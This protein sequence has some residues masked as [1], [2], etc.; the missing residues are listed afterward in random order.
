MNRIIPRA[1]LLALTLFA[2]TSV[3]AQVRGRI[4]AP[5]ARPVAVHSAPVRNAP[6]R[7]AT[8]LT[9]PSSTMVRRATAIAHVPRITFVNS[10]RSGV[11]PQRTSA[12]PV[13]GLG[14]SYSDYFAMHPPNSGPRRG[15][16]RNRGANFIEPLLLFGMPG[17]YGDSGYVDDEPPA[18]TQ[19]EAP[20]PQQ[21]QVI[22]VLP[23]G[24]QQGA[25]ATEAA[26]TLSA[27]TAQ[28]P[29]READ[30]SEYIF[31][32]RD[33]KLLFANGFSVQGDQIV[34]I[35]QDGVRRKV[36]LAD[37]DVDAT[38]LLNEQR[39]TTISLPADKSSS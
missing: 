13:P 24:A 30:T 31:L 16:F 8:R 3:N 36:A 21:P 11:N 25:S 23:P 6:V 19:P 26:S 5:P 22:Y 18:E 29:S 17:Y 2:A 39:G 10:T 20:A 37:L 38:R 1:T 32:L 7:V 33:G 34:F 14:F 35:T 12:Y 15:E 4:A 27:P 9:T 28:T